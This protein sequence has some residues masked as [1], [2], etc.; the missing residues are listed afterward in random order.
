VDGNWW[1]CRRHEGIA[2]RRK[3]KPVPCIET[4]QPRPVQGVEAEPTN[5]AI[6]GVYGGEVHEPGQPA[7]ACE[8]AQLTRITLPVGASKPS[9]WLSISSRISP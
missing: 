2:G 9:A 8:F 1:N 7:S 5:T 4:L 6:L 3:R